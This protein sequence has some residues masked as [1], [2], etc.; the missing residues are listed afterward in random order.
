MNY[1]TYAALIG[2]AI[3]DV[4]NND[5][6]TGGNA[7]C[8]T[9]YNAVC[10]ECNSDLGEDPH[11]VHGLQATD[12][13]LLAAGFNVDTA[14]GFDAFIIKTKAGCTSYDDQFSWLTE[15]GTDC[16]GYEW[17][18]KIGTANDGKV[19]KALWVAESPDGSYFVAVGMLE[20]SSGG[21]DAFVSKIDTDGT[22]VW[23][24]TYEDGNNNVAE[25]VIFAA[26][27]GIVIGGASN[28][29][30]PIRELIFKSSG[31]FEDGTPFIAKISAI[32]AAGSSEPSS[33]EWLYENSEVNGS[34]RSIAECDLGNIFAI[35]GPKTSIVK[36]AA[37]GTETWNTA[38]DL[39]DKDQMNDLVIINT[40]LY[41]A[42][43][44]Y[45]D[46][47]I[48]GRMMKVSGADG[49]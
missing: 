34:T 19:N 35:G 38:S 24:M 18:T 39:G 37:D 43:H 4:D 40:S 25:T 22:E 10:G 15:D 23:T 1:L 14:G 33:F 9:H 27:G 20:N 28:C 45:T 2:S 30:M 46:T 47:T 32:D 5:D 41:L 31:V 42:G 17:V 29:D 11:A 7:P 21:S 3:A 49:T 6:G 8:M 16:S 13:G 26:D 12:G 36:L 44:T 48:L